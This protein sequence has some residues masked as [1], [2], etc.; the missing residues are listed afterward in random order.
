MSKNA[1][2]SDD[3]RPP[4]TVPTEG[5]FKGTPTLSLP[6]DD[7]KY[8]LTMGVKKWRTVLTHIKAV[9]AFLAKHPAEESDSEDELCAKLGI[10]KEQLA[11]M[12]GGK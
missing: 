8:P 2:S 4:V 9:E 11:G 1:R 10:T 6:M 7:P 12:R 3:S 5:E